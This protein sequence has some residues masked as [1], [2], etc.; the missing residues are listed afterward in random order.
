[1]IQWHN[2]VFNVKDDHFFEDIIDLIY[3]QLYMMH[4]V[5]LC[6]C[7]INLN[8]TMTIQVKYSL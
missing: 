5:K 1:M 2:N 4:L 3:I 7:T 6:L 8:L